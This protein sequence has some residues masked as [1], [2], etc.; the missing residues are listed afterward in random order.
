MRRSLEGRVADLEARV[1]ARD[2]PWMI[3]RTVRAPGELGL[4][5]WQAQAQG[6]AFTRPDDES[7]Q[8]FRARVN[9]A[10]AGDGGLAAV[11][12]LAGVRRAA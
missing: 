11:R 9:E 1:P 10:M 12:V 2:S 5:I 4:P 7:E 3:W 8:T 6:R